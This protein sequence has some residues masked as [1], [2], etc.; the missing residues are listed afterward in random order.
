MDLP[1]IFVFTWDTNGVRICQNGKDKKNC[2]YFNFKETNFET[3]IGQS[4]ILVFTTQGEPDSNSYFHQRL[5]EDFT[6]K[7]ETGHFVKITFE[8]L[9]GNVVNKSLS[10]YA[11]SKFEG[12]K[13]IQQSVFIKKDFMKHVKEVFNKKLT[14]IF[15]LSGLHRHGK[16]ATRTILCE[17]NTFSSGAIATYINLKKYGTVAIISVYFPDSS[18]QSQ[19]EESFSNYDTYREQVVSSNRL[20]FLKIINTLIDEYKQELE[21]KYLI[22]AGDFNYEIDNFFIKNKSG[23]VTKTAELNSITLRQFYEHDEFVRERNNSS[24]QFLKEGINDT[25]PQFWPTWNLNPDREENCVKT[26]GTIDG[27][28]SCYNQ[29]EDQIGWKDRIF[30]ATSSMFRNTGDMICSKYDSF[31]NTPVLKSNHAAVWGKFIIPYE[32]PL[33]R[34]KANPVFL[35]AEERRIKNISEQLNEVNR[36]ELI[37]KETQLREKEVELAYNI[38]DAE[39]KAREQELLK[40][41]NNLHTKPENKEGY[42]QTGINAAYSLFTTPQASQAPVIYDK[43]T[44]DPLNSTEKASASTATSSTTTNN[45]RQSNFTRKRNM[46]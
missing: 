3:I 45:T 13:T 30:Y 33:L 34:P 32:N 14:D 24:F 27:K 23:D 19:I 29:T 46:I 25:G 16:S 1:N 7:K 42:I 12:H 15:N 4:N 11:K 17:D 37:R 9:K 44:G 36:I 5:M 2:A 38:K 31:D 10:A 21:I 18:L 20:C 22:M 41:A 8:K 6:K 39:L 28:W 40:R 26:A 43:V 35:R